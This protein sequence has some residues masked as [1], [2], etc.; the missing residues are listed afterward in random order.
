[1]PLVDIMRIRVKAGDVPAKVSAYS[2]CVVPCGLWRNTGEVNVKALGLRVS[3]DVM[4]E[5]LHDGT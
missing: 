3:L 1:M 5:A 2:V 4:E